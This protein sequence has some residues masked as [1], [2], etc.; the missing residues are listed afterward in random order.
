VDGQE[1]EVFVRATVAEPVRHAGSV[2]A[3]SADIAHEQ[4][5]T[6]FDEA[7]GVWLCPAAETVRFERQALGGRADDTGGES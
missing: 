5:T 4:A 3:P 1:W 2:T 6:L 7:V